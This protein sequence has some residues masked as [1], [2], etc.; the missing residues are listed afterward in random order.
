MFTGIVEEIGIIRSITDKN[1]CIE[2]SKV[3]ENTKVGDSISVNGVCLTVT[4]L[5]KDCFTADVSPETLKVSS[6]SDLRCGDSVNLE[7]ALLLTDRLGGHIV[8]GHIDT[9]GSVSVLSKNNNFYNLKVCFNSIYRKYI[10]KKGS[11]SINGISLTIAD[12]GDDFVTIAII[13]HT[14]ENTALKVL[15]K[16][17]NVNIEFDILAKYVEKNL[18]STDNSNITM[19]FLERNG[20]V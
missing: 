14:F 12:S 10:V 18:L 16:G 3:L 17:D 11:I 5:S 8:S 13:P 19:N 9:I 2:C 7:R 1:I 15:K 6:L 20:F 4:T